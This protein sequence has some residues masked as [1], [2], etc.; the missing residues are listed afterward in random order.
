MKAKTFESRVREI[1]KIANDA[2]VENILGELRKRGIGD[3]FKYASWCKR[4]FEANLQGGYKRKTTFTSDFTIAEFCE[5]IGSSNSIAGTLKTSLLN[6]RDNIEY[7]AEM[8]IV[9]N[10][11]SWEHHHRGNK[12]YTI[13]YSQLYYAVK[14]LYFDWFAEN[15]E[16]IDYYYAFVD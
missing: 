13:L 2:K 15:T 3:P 5:S 16:A 4:S 1:A 12:G 10:M 9:L 7:F 6:Y 11:K 8:I 14:D